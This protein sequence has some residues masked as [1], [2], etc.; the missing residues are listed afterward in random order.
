MAQTPFNFLDLDT[1]VRDTPHDELAK[2]RRESPVHWNRQGELWLV[3]RY[4]DIVHREDPGL[5]R[6]P[7]PHHRGHAASVRGTRWGMITNGLA[8]LD[9]PSIPA[10]AVMSPPSR[11]APSPP[12]RRR[13]APC[14]E[15]IDRALQSATVI[16]R[17]TSR[18]ACPSRC[19]RGRAGFPETSRARSTGR[20]HG[21]PEIRSSRAGRRARSSRSCTRM[22]SRL[23]PSRRRE[24]KNDAQRARHA[25]FADGTVIQTNVRALLLVTVDR[26]VRHDSQH[27]LGRDARAARLSAEHARLVE[28]PELVPT[29]VEEMLRWETRPSTS[30][31]RDRRY[32]AARIKILRGSASSVL[33]SANRDEEVFTNPEV[34]RRAPAKRAPRVRPLPHFCLARPGAHAGR[35]RCRRDRERKLRVE[36]TGP[37]RRARSNFRTASDDAVK[38]TA[39]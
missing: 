26:S 9:P 11:R 29:A 4:R 3:T 5:F 35:A 6:A 25:K 12:W 39:P 28:A 31:D 33:R 13:S 7:R 1:F 15:V 22:R 8:H 10:S 2:L 16:L 14:V 32:R 19:A 20:R 30:A 18:S 24:P 36:A 17:Q 34:R 38:I 23:S 27:H 21:P 37:L